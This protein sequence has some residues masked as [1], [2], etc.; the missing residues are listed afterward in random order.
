M[1]FHQNRG[2]EKKKGCL[3]RRHEFQ[4]ENGGTRT[5]RCSL[6]HLKVALMAMI[7]TV[8][9]YY[10]PDTW[11]YLPPYGLGFLPW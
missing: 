5:T 10:K 3:G 11:E 4:G 9:G 2:F 8:K 7:V 1:G 6:W